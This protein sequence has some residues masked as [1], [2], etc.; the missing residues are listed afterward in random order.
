MFENQYRGYMMQNAYLRGLAAQG[1]DMLNYFGVMHPS[2]TNY[3]ASIAAELCNVTSDDQ[4]PLLPQRSI[5]D[6]IEESPFNLRWKAY[7]ESYIKQNTPWTPDL[8]PKDEYP[9]VIKHNPF[10]SFAGIVR[11]K[12]R[13][14]H[15]EDEC[16]FW[17]D[18]LNGNFPEYAWFTPN[19][20]NDGHYTDGTQEEPEARAPALVDQMAAWLQSFFGALKFPGPNSHLP[21]RT[22]VVVTTDESDFEAVYDAD[23]KYTYDGPNQIYTI[24]LGDMLTPGVEEEGYNHY[25]LIRTIEKNFGL[26]SLGK[27]DAGANWF[28][29]LWGNRFRWASP[30]ATPI[31]TGGSLALA[32][33]HG[34]LYAVYHGDENRLRF[35]TFDGAEWSTE[36]SIGQ[37]GEGRLA[38]ARCGDELVLVYRGEDGNFYSLAYTLQNGWASR[39]PQRIAGGAV[40]N[41]AMAAYD[42]H[43]NLMLVYQQASGALSSLVFA[44]GS[45]AAEATPTG[46][47]TDAPIA[48]SA[49]GSSLYLIYRKAGSHELDV[50][51]YNTADFNVVTVQD[52][53]WSGPYDNTTKDCWSPTAFPVAHFSH[54][55]SQLTPGEQEPLTKVYEAGSPLVAATLEGVL[56]VAHPGVNNPLVITEEFSI[57]GLLTAEKPVSYKKSD[58]T[59]TSN[60]YGTLAEAGWSNQRPIN[61]VYNREGGA[62]AMARF[63]SEI[64]L[65]FQ[66]DAGRQI[67]I[68]TGRTSAR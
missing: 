1:I 14:M 55:A 47:Q 67:Y 51:S 58:E 38:L 63:G 27:N 5:V 26:S 19:M 34:A 68:C 23:D 40:D 21:P 41:I 10:S 12:R 29:F 66:P 60:G 11:N 24:L 28:Q 32:E 39:P 16:Q 33:Y 4:P 59:T 7:M 53:Q 35:R 52:S 3:I 44:N 54:A 43:Q 17:K 36:Q 22:L 48:L 49:L 30:S 56:H 37:S 65:A 8:V 45:W 50:L 9:Y 31:E 15:I 64:A 25:S 61:G 13:W 42:G 6:L 57:G 2:Q 62:M 46:Q 18:L 20:W